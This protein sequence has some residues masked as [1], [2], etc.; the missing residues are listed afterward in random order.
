[1]ADNEGR[2]ADGPG[3]NESE[4]DDAA[5]HPKLVSRRAAL[6]V[7]GV[8]A[9]GGTSLVAGRR[10][11]FSNTANDRAV[12]PASPPRDT[13]PG[14]TTATTAETTTTGVAPGMAR[15]SDPASW[16]GAVPGEGD[17]ATVTQP[18][19]LDVDAKVAGVEVEAA[20]ELVFDPAQ[21]H[22]LTSSGNV[23]VHGALR[24]RPGSAAVHQ[25][26]SIVGVDEGRYVGGETE[27]PQDTDVG[28]WVLHSGVI[29]L[30][31]AQ[32]AAWT[33]LGKAAEAG[34]TSIAVD[35][36]DGWQV[37]DEIVVT[38]TESPHE[39]SEHFM[40][41]DRRV[42][43]SVAG[44]NVTLDQPL[45]H[46]HPFVTVRPGV[47]HRAE[48][49][50]LTR[51][52]RIEGTPEGKSHVTI[53]HGQAP[54]KVGWV[55]LR[56]VGPKEVLGRYAL[57][58][59]MGY[60][61]VRG[62]TVDGVVAYDCANHAF[63]PHLSNGVTYRDCIV[64]DSA[65]HAYWWD[66]AG[67]GQQAGDVPSNDIVWER[68]VASSVAAGRDA[69]ATTSFMMGAGSGNVCKGCVAT[70]GSGASEGATGFRWGSGSNDETN[71]W[72]F[73][74]NV[75]HNNS[76]SGLFFWQNN[77][78]RTIVDRHTIYHCGQGIYAGSYINL[79]SYR[80]CVVYGC[81]DWGLIIAATPMQGLTSPD[82][83]VT[84]E[85]MYVDQLGSGEYAVYVEAHQLSGDHVTKITNGTFKGAQKAQVGFPDGGE[86]RQMYDFTDCTFEG[87]AFWFGEGVPAD[88]QIRVRGG[89]LGSFDLHPPGGAGDHRAE[90]NGSVTSV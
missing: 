33:H 44:K 38:A 52:V 64:H 12:A 80:D 89:N 27:E 50:N 78:P 23:V 85:N 32:K 82:E 20:G 76:H 21:S 62:S 17:V 10:I 70:G 48:V 40:H 74:D 59:H 41:F 69:H 68:C 4:P 5:G 39:N 7:L 25:V 86:I 14:E 3:P 28:V 61:A 19:L 51:N 79:V 87:N 22:T 24:M 72:V 58:F 2:P 15:W 57:H 60:D 43:A 34:A 37:G 13:A 26:L 54:Q 31:G 84:Y 29:D 8:G 47:T 11:F 55:G 36:A 16:G 73:E 90:W 45:E 77:A 63:V 1:M 18:V 6:A 53:L 30:L 65:D 67:D 56:H 46:A 9:V 75:T 83:T 49:L 66:P 35:A 81:S 42:I 71:T 88:S